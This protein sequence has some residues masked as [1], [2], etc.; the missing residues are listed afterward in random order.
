MS[1]IRLPFLAHEVVDVRFEETDVTH[2]PKED[3]S[4]GIVIKRV[5]LAPH[6]D[7]GN[8]RG[9]LIDKACQLPRESV[10]FHFSKAREL[11]VASSVATDI[12]SNDP[13]DLPPRNQLV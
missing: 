1:V 10:R 2:F 4:V 11:G 6:L 7:L 3:L 5:F 13:E 8:Q 12:V 9:P